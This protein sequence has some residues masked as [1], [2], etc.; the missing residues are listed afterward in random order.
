MHKNIYIQLPLILVGCL[1]FSLA[2]FSLIGSTSNILLD[3]SHIVILYLSSLLMGIYSNRTYSLLKIIG[4]FFFMGVVPINEY[5]TNTFYWGGL[6]I[7]SLVLFKTNVIIIIGI[8]S[9]IVGNIISEATITVRPKMVTIFVNHTNMTILFFISCLVVSYYNDFN[10]TSV[11]TRGNIN[12]LDKTEVVSIAKQAIYIGIIRPLP[13]ILFLIYYLK[14]NN[15]NKKISKSPLRSKIA[16]ILLFGI[17]VF[18]VLP[19]SIPRFQAAALYIPILILF[20]PIWSYRYIMP[21]SLLGALLVIFPLLNLFR[22]YDPTNFQ[23]KYSLDFMTEGHFDAYQNFARLIELNLITHGEQ[24][25]TSILFFIPRSIWSEKS[26]GS[27]A[28]LANEANYSFNNISMPYIGEGYINFGVP[29]VIAFMFFLGI[30]VGYLDKKYWDGKYNSHKNTYSFI[31]LLLLGLFFFIMR[32][33]L[34]SS[35]SFTFAM[36]FLFLFFRTLLRVRI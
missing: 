8:L 29:G 16:L 12:N 23:W 18:M 7:N 31:Y 35:L 22:Y 20:T 24:L 32:G 36:L 9:F 15:H 19:T 11:M 28:Y 2:I 17:A 5:L 30:L 21:L 34:L 27:G 3:V 13:L 1:I 25:K 33:D 4:V 26:I 10:L 14:Y 6:R